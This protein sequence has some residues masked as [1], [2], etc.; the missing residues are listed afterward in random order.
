MNMNIAEGSQQDEPLNSQNEENKN[1]E[2]LAE[3]EKEEEKARKHERLENMALEL[4]KFYYAD[5]FYLDNIGK[6][7]IM[8]DDGNIIETTFKIPTFTRHL[9]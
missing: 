2:D 9:T 5:N 8:R 6:V 4:F 3:K 1:L 7:E